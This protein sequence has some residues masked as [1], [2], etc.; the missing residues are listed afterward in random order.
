MV[1]TGPFFGAQA[2]GGT[3]QKTCLARSTITPGRQQIR[4]FPR[5]PVF[6]RFVHRD[7]LG[8]TFQLRRLAALIGQFANLHIPSDPLH[9]AVHK[10]CFRAA[11][12]F[13]AGDDMQP[14]RLAVSGFGDA[15]CVTFLVN[16]PHPFQIVEA[17]NLGPE[18]VD[19]HI[20]SVDQ[21]PV[22]IG[23]AFD[24]G[25]ATRLFDPLG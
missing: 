22:G 5:G 14:H 23:K 21:Y 4:K 18:Q 12:N 17:A 10:L 9:I 2:V 16:R 11:A 24:S 7:Y 15:G 6:A 3:D 8:D 1:R 13:T 25:C 20:A 19:D